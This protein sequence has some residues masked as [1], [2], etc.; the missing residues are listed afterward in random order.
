MSNDVGKNE[1][2]I[3]RKSKKKKKKIKNKSNPLKKSK[4]GIKIKD[5]NKKTKKNNITKNTRIINKNITKNI[6]KENSNSKSLINSKSDSNCKISINELSNYHNRK[7]LFKNYKNIGNLPT[8][9]AKNKNKVSTDNDSIYYGIIKVDLNNIGNYIPENSNQT[10]HNYTFNEAVKYD[11][12][13]ILKIFYIYL[14]SKQII[15]HTFLQKSPLKIFSLRLCLLIFMICT[16]L[17]L[18]ALLYLN[19]NISKKYRYTKSLFLFAFSDN[20]TVI[21]YSSLLCFVLMFLITKLSSSETSI[22]NIFRKEEEK[23]KANKKYKINEKRKNEIFIEIEK[24]LKRLKIKL[25]ILIIIQ[26]LLL[27]FFWYYVTAFCH[28]YK[29]TQTSW[30]WDSCLSI[31]SRTVIELLFALL[32]AK[33]YIVSVQSSCYTLYR[34]LLFFYDFS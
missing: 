18:N 26:I 25:L 22:R 10:L 19:D 32:F 34:I 30:L 24:I 4:K 15:F 27:L 33:L 17:A 7:K 11:S 3:K 29:S 20:I 8:E 12:R 5:G 28:V 31:L 16:D 21:I 14:L 6:H 9:D 13:S 23:I 1:T 2:K